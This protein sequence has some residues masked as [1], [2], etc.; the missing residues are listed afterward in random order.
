MPQIASAQTPCDEDLTCQYLSCRAPAKGVPA[1]VWGELRPVDTGVLP[2][3]RDSTDFDEFDPPPGPLETAAPFW[4]S[5][6]IENSWIFAAVDTGLHIWN[7]AN[8][9]SPTRSAAIGR[10]AFPVWTTDPHLARPVLDVDA[11]PGNDNV[12]AVALGTNGIAAGLAVFNTTSKTSPAARYADTD[13]NVQ[14][15]WATNIGGADYAFTATKGDGLLV[16][17]LSLAQARTTLCTEDTPTST[18]GVYVGRV[19]SRSS[20]SYIDGV[21][22]GTSS[23]VVASSGG[24]A[25]G[26]EIWNVSNPAAPVQVLTVTGSEFIHGV[27]LWRAGSSYYLATRVTSGSG[28]QARI[29]NVS[30]ISTASCSGLGSPNWTFAMPSS[31]AGLFVTYSE[32]DGRRFVYFGHVDRCNSG[33]QTEWLF[34]VSN[35]GAPFD[36]TPPPGLVGGEPTGYWGW[37]YRRNPTGFNWVMPRMGKFSGRYFYRAALGIFDIHELTSGG[38]PTAS[39]TYSPNP[40]YAGQPASFQDTSIGVPNTWSWTFQGGTPGSSTQQNPTGV[41]FATPGSKQVT[42]AVTNNFGNDSDTQ[43]I[44]VLDPT[45]TVASV[46]VSPNPAFVCQPIT[47]TATNLTGFPTPTLSWTVGQPSLPPT[48]TA[49]NVN[50]FIWNSTGAAAGTYNAT[51]TATNT[52]GT[53]QATSPSLTLNALPTLPSAGSFTPTNDA[54]TGGTVQFHVNVPG[55]TEW[56]WSFGDG[57]TF[58]TGCTTSGIFSNDP[59]AGPNPSHSYAAVN[60]YQVTV[61]VKNCIEGAR[62]SAPL[63][64]NITQ[65]APLIADFAAQG[66]FCTGTGC[67]G[68][69]G[70]INFTDNSQGNPDFYDYDWDGDGQFE[71]ANR[72]TPAT[73][74]SYGVGTFSP[75]LRIRRG[76]ESNTFTHRPISLSTGGGGNPPALSVTGPS[77]GNVGASLSYSATVSNC[78]PQPSS[79]NWTVP[80]DGT[81]NGSSTGASIQVSFASAGSK[82]ISVT[83]GTGG[84]SGSSG[85]TA[86]KGVTINQTTGGGGTLAASFTFSPASPAVGQSVS[87][88]AAA[89]TGSPTAYSWNF[90]DNATGGGAQASHTYTQAG[91]YTVTLQISK[92]DTSCSFGFCT[93]STTRSVVVGGGSGC[94][95]S[96]PAAS[97]T[98]SA[99]CDAFVCRADVGQSVSFTSTSTNTSSHD[100][101]FGDGDSAS[102]VTVTHTFDQAGPFTVTL[103]ARDGQNNTSTANRLFEIS[104][105]AVTDRTLILPWVADTEGT[106]VQTTDLYVTNPGTTAMQVEITFRKRGLVAEDNPPVVTRTIPAKGTLFVADCVQALFNRTNTFGFLAIVAKNS[107]LEPV[108]SGLNRTF[109][110]DGSTYG[111]LIPGLTLTEI[112]ALGGANGRQVILGLHDTNERLSLFGLT[113]SHQTPALYRLRFTD[114]LGNVF[115]QSAELGIGP[116][117]QKQFQPQELRDDY[118]VQ[119]L[120]DFRVEVVQTAGNDLVAYTDLIRL[121]TEDPSFVQ[122]SKSNLAKIYLLAA[123]STPAF[124]NALFQSDVLLANPTPDVM[125]LDVTY[126]NLGPNATP[127]APQTITLLPNETQRITNVLSTLFGLNNN[128]GLLTFDS[129]GANGS[130]PMIH[131]ET[132]QNGGPSNRYGFFMPARNE[133]EI[134]SSGQRSF[135]TGLRQQDGEASTTLWLLNP[136]TDLAVY[137]LIYHGVDGSELGRTND[138]FVPAGAVRQINPGA[139]PLPAGGTADPFSVEIQ[140][141]G[142]QLIAAGQVVINR[143]NDPA[144]VL[145]SRR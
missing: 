92:P 14:Q 25:Q 30:C 129:D 11:P 72:T 106:I 97:F 117:G 94:G 138:F 15:V 89:S 80:A 130:F 34:D 9:A 55:A 144:Y 68:N 56:C 139:H 29:Y 75:K 131:G 38:P 142:G 77:S 6:D 141:V 98:T 134:V 96:C 79:F 57:S 132:Y 128:V 35:P 48:A 10:A 66:L 99:P 70:T 43:N 42:L 18:C 123:S 21:T 114:R 95:A 59:I 49:G 90:G 74:H 4:V 84:C 37:Y 121:G 85:L 113:N 103:T 107:S 125:Q 104:Q 111:Q 22:S 143:S 47:F 60:T 44:T 73:S 105:P 53:A 33:L 116:W 126:R 133:Q 3:D 64:V 82:T 140:V 26:L 100:W 1:A 50:P 101:N 46:T 88:D 61:Q 108:A 17:N 119:G 36:I 65:V 115:S 39:F 110:A 52:A 135:L 13:K 19:G 27:A 45:P 102:G 118:G 41:V 32:S 63:G 8:P 12:V 62:T 51:V 93:A 23:F 81:I 67:F 2:T 71:Q 24:V 91:T 40:L 54:F 87:F 86:N 69:A 112:D 83:A 28:T 16:Y 145:G 58:P 31:G 136:G 109:Q 20:F 124:N 127:S 5:L 76:A 7:A 137:T 122:A 120:E 78:S